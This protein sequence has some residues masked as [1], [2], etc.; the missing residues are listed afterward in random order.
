MGG[1]EL[2]DQAPDLAE[3][4]FGGSVG[5]HHSRVIDV[6]GRL[7]QQSAN[8]ELLNIDLGP[9]ERNELGGIASTTVG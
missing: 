1:D 2:V 7:V 4:E 9:H 5:I 8:R 6:L 3:V